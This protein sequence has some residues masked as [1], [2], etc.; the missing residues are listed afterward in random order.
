MVQ[1][2][3]LNDSKEKYIEIRTYTDITS[4]QLIIW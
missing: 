1:E 3:A 4:M 2:I